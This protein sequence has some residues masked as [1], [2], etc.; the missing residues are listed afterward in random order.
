MQQLPPDIDTCK[1]IIDSPKLRVERDIFQSFLSL[2]GSGLMIVLFILDCKPRMIDGNWFLSFRG[3]LFLFCIFACL[4]KAY[5][6]F[7]VSKEDKA[8]RWL[9]MDFITRHYASTSTKEAEQ[10]MDVNRP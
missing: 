3:A 9:A 2:V 6:S 4:V 5:R 10:L 1:K 7:T 8:I